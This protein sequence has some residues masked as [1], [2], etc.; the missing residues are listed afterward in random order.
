MHI[1]VVQLDKW[2]FPAWFGLSAVVI[3][4]RSQQNK[5][6]ARMNKHMED[7]E[8]DIRND[9]RQGWS[10]EATPSLSWS[11]FLIYFRKCLNMIKILLETKAD[12]LKLLQRSASKLYI[13]VWALRLYFLRSW[14]TINLPRSEQSSLVAWLL[15]FGC[16]EKTKTN[17]EKQLIQ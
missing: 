13:D 6:T 5:L 16:L 11:T 2:P 3:F 10:F 7:L 9:I 8:L 4:Y 12:V 14:V 17:V 1:L 15:Q